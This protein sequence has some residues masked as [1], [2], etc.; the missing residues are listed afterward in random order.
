MMILEHV[1]RLQ[2]LMID[3]IIGAHQSQRRFLV[4]VDALPLDLQMRFGEQRDHPATAVAPLLVARDATLRG[5]Q[6]ALGL[7]IPTGMKD[8]RTIGQ[9]SEGF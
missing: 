2:V 8:A 6:C 9:R 4:E 5:F 3:H 1:G 7:A